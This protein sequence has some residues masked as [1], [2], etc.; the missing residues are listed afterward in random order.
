MNKEEE[1][2][3]KDIKIIIAFLIEQESLHDF[4][5]KLLRK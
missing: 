5:Y 1:N 4:S 3:A 2:H